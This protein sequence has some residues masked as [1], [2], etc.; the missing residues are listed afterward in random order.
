MTYIHTFIHT[1][2][3]HVDEP[4]GLPVASADSIQGR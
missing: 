3:L 4:I 2:I 1:Y